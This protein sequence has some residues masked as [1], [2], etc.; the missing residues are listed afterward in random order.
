MEGLSRPGHSHLKSFRESTG[1]KKETG[2]RPAAQQLRRPLWTPENHMMAGQDQGP[3]W[4]L[5][6]LAYRSE[7][8]RGKAEVLPSGG[9]RI[10]TRPSRQRREVSITGQRKTK[11][12]KN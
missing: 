7:E 8:C 11:N 5:G 10:K 12:N 6:A 4:D 9:P 1:L 2:R 3:G